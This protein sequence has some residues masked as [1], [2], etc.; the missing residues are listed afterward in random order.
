MR[1]QE[2]RK[3]IL[4]ALAK[5]EE[6]LTGGDLA[7]RFTVS[8][9]VIVQDI[10][11]LRARGEE[12]LATPRGYILASKLRKELITAT[13]VCQHSPAEVETELLAIVRQ[14]GR[15]L[16]VIVEHPIYG[17]LRGLLMINS[18]QD[19]HRFMEKISRTAARPLSDLTEGL[20]LH[21]VEV[22]DATSLQEI[23]MALR[24]LGFLMEE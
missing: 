4:D 6:P 17:E 22:P 16:D 23:K 3:N 1:V 10:A 14:G 7:K 12:V 24:E 11:L 18:L 9:Q 5:A 15:V 8:R 2:R 19:V 20:H 21:T 13:L